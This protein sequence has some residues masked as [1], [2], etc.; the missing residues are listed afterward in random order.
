MAVKPDLNR[1]H[2]RGKS[3]SGALR[4]SLEQSFELTALLEEKLQ[5]KTVENQ[6]LLQHVSERDREVKRLQKQVQE[7]SKSLQQLNDCN[8]DLRTQ[9]G[10]VQT[11]WQSALARLEGAAKQLE[12]WELNGKVLRE[13]SEQLS[14]VSKQQAEQV[15]SLQAEN[16]R[17]SAANEV[18]RSKYET[19]LR[20]IRAQGSRA[21][22]PRA[23]RRHQSVDYRW[24]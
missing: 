17:L 6:Q 20:E 24:S 22:L 10:S 16:S 4:R 8:S 21:E 7:A 14:V 5:A 18:L 2:S 9:L 23:E 11:D 12:Q 1:T 3:S 15:R 13:Q 19:A